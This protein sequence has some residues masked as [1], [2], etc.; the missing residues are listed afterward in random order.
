MDYLNT[1][2]QQLEQAITE[3]RREFL[4]LTI[5]ILQKMSHPVKVHQCYR[6]GSRPLLQ[7]QK[8][9]FDLLDLPMVAFLHIRVRGTQIV[10]EIRQTALELGFL[11]FSPDM[12]IVG[13]Q[14]SILYFIQNFRGMGAQV[15][16]LKKLLRQRLINNPMVDVQADGTGA[17]MVVTIASPFSL[18]AMT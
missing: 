17:I 5:Q 15:K 9:C 18:R 13:N 7:S 1:V 14:C 11:A 3:S 6:L 10:F 2:N 12:F 16:T 4:P 8:L